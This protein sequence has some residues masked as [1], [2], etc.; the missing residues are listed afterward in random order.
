MYLFILINIFVTNKAMANRD[1]LLESCPTNNQ[2][3]NHPVENNVFSKPLEA[4]STDPLTGFYRDSY[5]RTGQ[6]DRGVHV[7]C[8]TMTD[9]FLT[10]T[11]AKGND[12]STPAPQYGFPGLKVGDKW[13]LCAARWLEAYDDGVA[14]TVDL[15]ATSKIALDTVPLSVLS[16]SKTST[17]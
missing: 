16:E 12:L 10:Y 15:S 5:C 2:V 4:C 17:R 8:A 11:K 13:C 1:C 14:P 7:V 3:Q 6:N 9:K